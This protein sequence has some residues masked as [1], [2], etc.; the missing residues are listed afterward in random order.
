MSRA[1]SCL[2][3]FQY[4]AM[5]AAILDVTFMLPF[6]LTGSTQDFGHTVQVYLKRSPL[7]L[8][9]MFSH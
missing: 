7:P 2:P 9:Q 8:T 3:G 4:Q 5:Q 6:A 1:V